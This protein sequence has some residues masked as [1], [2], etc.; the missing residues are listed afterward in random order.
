MKFF[1]YIYLFLILLSCNSN[2]DVEFANKPKIFLEPTNPIIGENLTIYYNTNDS[3]A[4][5]Q[6]QDTLYANI[7]FNGLYETIKYKLM[8]E[9][10]G[11][12]FKGNMIVPSDAYY[13]TLS[14]TPKYI[15]K[16]N[17][18]IS[19]L[20][21]NTDGN[22]AKGALAEQILY[23]KSYDE[24]QE[25][26]AEDTKLY[27]NNNL[28]LSS[29]SKMIFG[30]YMNSDSI[31][32]SADSLYKIIKTN[33][34]TDT[35]DYYSTLIACLDIY[36]GLKD[37]DKCIDLLEI[38][39][40]NKKYKYNY[41]NIF[42]YNSISNISKEIIQ[43]ELN[44]KL[45][46]KLKELI[47]SDKSL[48]FNILYFRNLIDFGSDFVDI[49]IINNTIEKLFAINKEITKGDEF[50]EIFS[51]LYALY[52]IDY[53]NKNYNTI[54]NI[55]NKFFNNFIQYY[56]SDFWKKINVEPAI[57][58]SEGQIG[59]LI[60]K[61]NDAYIKIKD[62]TKAISTILNYIK[63]TNKITE[64]N[65]GSLSLMSIKLFDLAFAQND[66]EISKLA[67][68]YAAKFSSPYLDSKFKEFNKKMNLLN[69]DTFMISDNIKAKSR[70][71]TKNEIDVININSININA[72][73][74]TIFLFLLD[75]SCPSCNLG[76]NEAID[77]LK[78][79]TNYKFKIIIS[80]Q[81]DKKELNELY[82]DNVEIHR[83]PE[84]LAAVFKLNM[85]PALFVI[86]QNKLVHLSK[87][88]TSE[89]SAYINLLDYK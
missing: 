53:H 44:N 68:N 27:P 54:I 5:F 69:I 4:V 37:W 14:I 23:S 70:F 24:A 31:L 36:S 55:N 78:A 22:P 13:F 79:V 40:D 15:Y 59:I 81:A 33:N 39:L 60:E 82:G 62:T 75:D 77:T 56:K 85:L 6:N 73:D 89:K 72:S 66:F 10:D 19:S 51:S 25:Y 63:S 83:N 80:S 35:L 64:F 43:N 16:T 34:I 48:Y 71:L 8:L 47:L 21:L 88:I 46:L 67:L 2:K 17:E 7:E 84:N 86:R 52:I 12:V 65:R 11:E 38:I 29:L 32:H 9:K 58:P 3:S 49:I 1:I 76:L 26:Y 30:S 20:V 42:L 61:L 28:R 74:S 87:N 41:N 50:I 57:G 45:S 18:I